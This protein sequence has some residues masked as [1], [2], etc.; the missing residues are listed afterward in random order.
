LFLFI[1]YIAPKLLELPSSLLPLKLDLC[2]NWDV[3]SIRHILQRICSEDV[4]IEAPT[5]II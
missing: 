4:V 1:V 2:A 3:Q 5:N